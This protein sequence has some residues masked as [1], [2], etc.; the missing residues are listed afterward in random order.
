MTP[1]HYAAGATTTPAVISALL[2]AGADL[3]A[4]DE[5]GRTPLHWAARA[6]TTPAV[7][8][9][10]L[11]AGADPKARTKAGQLPWDLAQDNAALKDTAAW[12]RLNDGRF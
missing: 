8:S 6:T 4:Q 3:T 7:I 5:N 11:A 9:A 1:L 2:A 12:W 10:L